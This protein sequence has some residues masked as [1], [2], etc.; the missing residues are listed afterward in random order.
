M[1]EF[2]LQA[3]ETGA[4][5]PLVEP[6]WLEKH[7]DDPD[8]RIVDAT[9]QIKLWPFPRIRSGWR[10]FKRS[11]IPGATFADLLKISD[12][13]RPSHTFTMPT[14]EHFADHMGRLGIGKGTR[15]V[16]YDGRENMWA[17]RLWWMLRTFGFDDAAVLNGGWTA[18]RLEDRPVSSKP[19]VY[20]AAT[21]TPHVRSGLI[22]GKEEVLSAIEDSKTCIVNAL[23][24]RQHRG[25]RKEY[26]GRG[27][28]P[29]AKNVTAWEILD[30]ETM[31]YRPV[32]ELRKLFRPMLEAERVITYCGGGIASSSD[33]FI[34][35][36]LGHKNVAVYDGGLMEWSADR[37]LPLEL[38]E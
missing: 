8:L 22:V 7:L 23:G 13:G 1:S 38:G 17:T 30:R 18:W 9:V 11:H 35:H 21:F 6:E 32:E 20:P 5:H 4:L 2:N 15:V 31:R 24:R 26:G 19:C 28:I 36:L 29:G 25:E 34:L 37:S 10:E 12:P 27:H 33:A 3:P 14:A 16:L